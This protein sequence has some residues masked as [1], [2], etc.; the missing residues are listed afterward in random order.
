MPES[1]AERW[2]R[3]TEWRFPEAFLNLKGPL[4]RVGLTARLWSAKVRYRLDSMPH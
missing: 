1:R 3:R 2:S 4:M